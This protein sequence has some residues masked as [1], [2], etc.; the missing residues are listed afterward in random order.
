M[1]AAAGATG[2]IRLVTSVLGD[3]AHT[4][5]ARAVSDYYAFA[6]PDCVRHVIDTAATTPDQIRATIAAYD[7]AGLDELVF[8]GN[9]VNPPADRPARRPPR[10][11]T[12][13]PDPP[14]AHRLT[15]GTPE[16]LGPRSPRVATVDVPRA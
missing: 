10:R 11:R 4:S 13:I 3:H 8:V 2:R 16:A 9:D 15:P 1:A 14:S 6:G 12:H 5:L 7:A